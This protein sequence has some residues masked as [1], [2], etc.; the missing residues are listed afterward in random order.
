MAEARAEELARPDTGERL[1]HLPR[2]FLRCGAGVEKRQ[3]A[4]HP[5]LRGCDGAE[6]QRRRGDAQGQKMPDACARGEE[7]A[8][9]EN[10]H[11]DRHRQMRL[12]KDEAD[13]RQEDHDE[14]QQA[15]L[16]VAHLLALLGGQHGAPH[17][18]GELR[19]LGWLQREEPEVHPAACAIDRGRDGMRKWQQGNQQQQAG[20]AEQRPGPV[21]PA[22]VVQSREHDRQ[23]AA[24]RRAHGLPQREAGADLATG[25]GDEARRAVDRGQPEDDQHR[26]DDGEQPALPGHSAA[27][28][29]RNVA[30]RSS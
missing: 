13:H 22:V 5:V 24:H 2:R 3:H 9:A 14:R 18:H 11:E 25:H 1:L 6:Q 7:Y 17:H 15:L 4:G 8:A 28:S 30:P 20:D 16:E 23:Q 21:P 12:E 27:M 19:Q 29:R 10:R 26:R